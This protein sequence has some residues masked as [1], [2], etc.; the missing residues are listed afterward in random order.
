[1][2]KVVVSLACGVLLIG[3]LLFANHQ[4]DDKA[5]NQPGVLSNLTSQL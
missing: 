1:M 5:S 3:G 2:R 4:Y